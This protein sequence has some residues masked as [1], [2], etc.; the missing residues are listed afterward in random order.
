MLSKSILLIWILICSAQVSQADSVNT[1]CNCTIKFSANESIKDQICFENVC[2]ELENEELSKIIQSKTDHIDFNA[3]TEE[4]NTDRKALRGEVE[5]FVS[6]LTY[7]ITIDND[8]SNPTLN[9]VILEAS[10]CDGLVYENSGYI[11]NDAY[12]YEPSVTQ[13][14]INHTTSKV[15]WWIGS[16]SPGEKRTIS[17]N[18]LYKVGESPKKE[19]TEIHL[20]AEIWGEDIYK[21][22]VIK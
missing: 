14:D 9:N 11:E 1:I 19:D 5:I 17:L 10:L 13:D 8:I 21:K 22:G 6:R 4:S 2:K 7:I 20:K 3:A 18:T 12:F 15:N 16:L